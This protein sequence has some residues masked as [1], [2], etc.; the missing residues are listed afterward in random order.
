MKYY[1]VYKKII[2]FL[3][4]IKVLMMNKRI[5]LFLSIAVSLSV[6]NASHFVKERLI[7]LD[8]IRKKRIFKEGQFTSSSLR[9]TARENWESHREIEKLEELEEKEER[10]VAIAKKITKGYMQRKNKQ[11]KREAQYSS[12]C[13]TREKAWKRKLEGAPEDEDGVKHPSPDSTMDIIDEEINKL[14]SI[15]RYA[16]GQVCKSEVVMYANQAELV[17]AQLD[18]FPW[19][20][21]KIA[22]QLEIFAK[23][24]CRNEGWR[25]ESCMTIAN[26]A[27]K[28]LLAAMNISDE[29]LEAIDRSKTSEQIFTEVRCVCDTNKWLKDDPQSDWSSKMYILETLAA[30]LRTECEEQNP[31]NPEQCAEMIGNLFK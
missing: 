30:G 4:N 31:D 20:K 7:K 5:M 29:E 17:L 22:R 1:E 11:E 24:Q 27:R 10:R 9:A 16:L 8:E 28:G 23:G 3:E 2:V 19:N 26:D 13:K 6:I 21:T 25:T 14:D 15:G 12:L 18:E